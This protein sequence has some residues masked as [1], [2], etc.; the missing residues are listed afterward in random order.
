MISELILGLA[1]IGQIQAPF[2][3]VN[4]VTEP[5]GEKAMIL[6]PRS[7]DRDKGAPLIMYHHGVGENERALL[8]DRLKAECVK[9][10]L[11]AGYILCG[12]N[13]H[14][15]NWGS[16]NAL[17]DYQQLY[18]L[19]L[20]RYNITRICFWSQSMGGISG[21]L[22]LATIPNVQG[23][24]GTYPV[25]NLD[26]MYRNPRFTSQIEAAFSFKGLSNLERTTILFNP[27]KMD[28]AK[29]TVPRVRFY[30]SPEDSVVPQAT[31]SDIMTKVF[32]KRKENVVITCKGEHGDPSHFVPKEYVEFFDR[33][34]P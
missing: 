21:L 31:N 11:D 24:L 23:W 27:V 29:V 12:S 25:A 20:R 15:N 7:Y 33:C 1:V 17:N 30:A 13:A 22:S 18:R 9:V 28:M 26:D 8:A 2:E 10:L 19:M 16:Q 6:V 14:G 34:K 3:E 32:G 5:G 4:T